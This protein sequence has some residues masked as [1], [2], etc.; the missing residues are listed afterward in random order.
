MKQLVYRGKGK[1]R[2]EDAEPPQLLASTDA[3]VR[4]VAAARCDLETAFFRHDLSPLL[5]LGVATGLLSRRLLA[6]FGPR[7]FS[8]P[9]PVGHECV[10]E[11]T[12]VGSDVKDRKVGDVVVVPYQVS[13]G[14]C[15]FCSRGRTAHCSTD[16]GSPI[17]AFGGFADT[18]KAWGGAFSD[19]LRIPFAD[20]MLVPLPG[21]LDPIAYAS[22]G[23]NIADGFRSVAP[24][25]S[26]LPGAPVL[27][28]GGCARSIGLYAVAVAKA[29]GSEE[30]VYADWD[31]ERLA[32]AD[33]LG[34][35]VLPGRFGAHMRDK[36]I[37]E[38]F[39]I[40][41]EASGKVSG[42]ELALKA[43]SVCG[44]CTV[45]ALHW[46]RRTPIPLWDMY[47]RNINVQTGLV[48][49][50]TVVPD[51][52]ALGRTG[53]LDLQTPISIVASWSDAP[54]ALLARSTKVVVHRERSHSRSATA[55]STGGTAQHP[56][57]ATL[58]G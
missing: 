14:F 2:F 5:R 33:K 58:S 51:V 48:D 42:F 47:S 11:V 12:Q 40:S 39:P 41:V 31:A 19:S 55:A 49:A 9:M 24:P 50:R 23:D 16:R 21:E 18:K 37:V 10:A 3:L 15:A 17:S 44:T 13:C 52:I 7:P 34:A 29:L 28:V 26:Q 57:S 43:L 46:S 27:V 53:R 32:A 6:D 1:L 35:R 54:D 25:L 56:A 36:S 22:A 45:V 4:P 38:R 20:H 8:G 30:V